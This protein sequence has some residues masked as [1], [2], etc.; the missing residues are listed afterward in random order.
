[1]KLEDFLSR[2]MSY[3]DIQ[4][5][6]DIKDVYAEYRKIRDNYTEEEISEVM[7]RVYYGTI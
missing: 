1:M 5:K 6:Y 2:E 3:R 7:N 4:R